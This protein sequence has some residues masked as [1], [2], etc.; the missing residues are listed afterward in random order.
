MALSSAQ[1][2]RWTAWY[3]FTALYPIRKNESRRRGPEVGFWKIAPIGCTRGAP[4][5]EVQ[6]DGPSH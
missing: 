6:D 2:V 3:H 1:P 5:F 4:I